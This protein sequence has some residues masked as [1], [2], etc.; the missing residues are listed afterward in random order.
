M[1]VNFPAIGRIEKHLAKATSNEVM[2][3]ALKDRERL[4]ER[5]LQR[6]ELPHLD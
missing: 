5:Q 4:F 2:L 1:A 3:F 6:H